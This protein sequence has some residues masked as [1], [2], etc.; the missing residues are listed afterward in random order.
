MNPDAVAQAAEAANETGVYGALAAARAAGRSSETAEMRFVTAA[1]PK[2]LRALA[3]LVEADSPPSQKALDAV[4]ALHRPYRIYAECGHT[5]SQHDALTEYGVEVV[6]T[7][8]FETCGVGFE[9]TVCACCCADQGEGQTLEC[10]SDHV[11]GEDCWPCPT[12]RA[13]TDTGYPTDEEA[14]S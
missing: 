2:E 9:R 14:Q 11:P 6:E 5:P 13:I 8:D 7:A 4:L 3:D 12:R 1:G 10:A